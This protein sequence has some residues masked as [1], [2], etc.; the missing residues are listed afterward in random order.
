MSLRRRA[1]AVALPAALLAAVVAVPAAPAAAAIPQ[2]GAAV[3]LARMS[4]PQRVGQVFMVGG[5]ATGVSSATRTAV[6]RYHAGN[7]MLTGRSY[8]GVTATARVTAGLRSLATTAA[9]AGVPLFIGTDQEGGKVQVLH[10]SGFSTIPSA[11]TQGTWSTSQLR[12]AAT[13]WARQLRA[14]GVN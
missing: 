1:V 4:L 6:S 14:A 7:V 13:T 3:V 2:G 8:L 11:L 12:A 9:T 5:A 10:G